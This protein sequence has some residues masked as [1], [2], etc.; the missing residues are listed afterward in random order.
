M[1]RS[2]EAG[3]SNPERADVLRVL[4]VLKIATADQIY[5]LER[6]HLGFRHTAKKPSQWKSARNK[7][8]RNAARDLIREGLVVAA[9]ATRGS[10]EALFGLTAKGLEAAS[11]ELGRPRGRWAASPPGRAGGGHSTRC[12]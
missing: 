9:G 5:R 12:R 8:H 4:G 1:G 6:P 7:S 10:G 3:S 11:Y 2:N